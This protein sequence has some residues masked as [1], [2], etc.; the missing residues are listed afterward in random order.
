MVLIRQYRLPRSVRR[1]AVTLHLYEVPLRAPSVSV[2]PTRRN[3]GDQSARQVPVL[4]LDDGE[5]LFDSR[6]IVDYLDSLVAPDR[7]LVPGRE[8]ARRAVLRVD[9]VATGLAEKLYERG[10]EFARRDPAKRDS[11]IIARVERQIDSALSLARK[12]CFRRRGCSETRC[13]ERTSWRRSRSPT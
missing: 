9:A 3:A 5:R 4:Q 1:V 11:A 12:P 7:R 13:R 10:Y 8:P 6:A 2:L